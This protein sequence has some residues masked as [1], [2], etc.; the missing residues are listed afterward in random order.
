MRLKE[1]LSKFKLD[2]IKFNLPVP[3]FIDYLTLIF[4][5]DKS[6]VRFGNCN[7]V[8]ASFLKQFS[9]LPEN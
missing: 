5:I 7:L 3:M 9:S 1:I 4:S 2:K 6:S 8:R